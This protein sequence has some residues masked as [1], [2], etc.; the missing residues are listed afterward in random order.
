MKVQIKNANASKAVQTAKRIAM[1][2][3]VV[4]VSTATA[5]A[6]EGDTTIDLTTGLAGVAI[7]GGLMASGTLKALPTY[8]AWGIKKALAMLR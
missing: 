8:A 3:G 5:F 4:L 7:I 2:T 6:A 1:T